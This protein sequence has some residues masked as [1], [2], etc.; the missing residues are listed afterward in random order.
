MNLLRVALLSTLIFLISATPEK[1]VMI[2]MIGDSTMANKGPQKY[3]ETGWGMVFHEYFKDGVT[4]DN[5]AMD[6]RST[7]SF[8]TEKRWQ[9]VYDHLKEGDYVFI[10]FGHND[11]KIERPAVGT[12]IEE[13]SENLKRFINETRS[14][15]AIPI[16]MTPIVR[17]IYDH[18]TGQLKNSHG[19]YPDAV[20]EVA[21]KEHVIFIDLLAK[22]DIL[23]QQ[24]GEEPSKK[25]YNFADSAQYVNYPKGI[26]D[27]THLSPLGA[28]KIAELAVQGIKEAGIPLKAMLK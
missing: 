9:G 15:K 1:P 5:R 23:V 6:G 28:H 21:A 13:F 20:R 17:R 14:K 8:I 4:I 16:L 3:P 7:K 24:T 10:E 18:S 19:L 11:E 25:F 2:Y 12:T 26:Q 27:V 22:S